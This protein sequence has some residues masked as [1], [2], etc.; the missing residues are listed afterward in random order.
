MSAVVQKDL[1]E[2]RIPGYGGGGG[3]QSHSAWHALLLIEHD[4]GPRAHR[5]R[6][7][8]EQGQTA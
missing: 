8:R 4:I 5:Q 2:G 1:W 7:G 3:A 6:E